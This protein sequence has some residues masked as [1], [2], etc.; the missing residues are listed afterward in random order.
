MKYTKNKFI[1]PLMAALVV[2][3]AFK[4]SAATA[5]FFNTNIIIINDRTSTNQ[6][7]IAT[8]YP[9]SIVVTGLTGMA[10]TK[11][12]V[13]IS[14]LTHAFVSDVDIALVSPQG[15]NIMLMSNVGGQNLP[16]AAVTNVTLTFDDNALF[17]CPFNPPLVSGTYKPTDYFPTNTTFPPPAPVYP[18]DT[19]LATFNSMDPNGTW[20]LFVIDD[21]SDHA[22]AISNGWSITITATSTD[23]PPVLLS[24]VPD[25]ANVVLS[26]T[27][28][29][30]GFTLKTTPSISGTPTWT[31][32]VPS[33]VVVAGRFTVTNAASG[34]RFYRLAK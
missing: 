22:G 13:T 20:S 19:N 18:M 7:A 9:S 25:N 4:V 34:T 3:L 12:T 1:L 15:T 8:P 11:V 32:A 6:P 21:V 27:N 29:L 5:T 33:P 10:I 28:T 17:D 14:N 16:G 31:N 24:I 26:W 23:A 2:G 30:V